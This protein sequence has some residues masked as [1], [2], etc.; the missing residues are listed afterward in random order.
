M[1]RTAGLL[2]TREA[3]RSR[4]SSLD[5]SSEHKLRIRFWM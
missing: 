4:T 3:A 5:I 1:D 2:L